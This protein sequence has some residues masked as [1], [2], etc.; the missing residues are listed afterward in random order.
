MGYVK[1]LLAYVRTCLKSQEYGRLLAYSN[2]DVKKVDR[3]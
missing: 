1:R 3:V 2:A